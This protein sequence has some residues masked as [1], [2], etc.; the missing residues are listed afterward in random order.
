[1]ALSKQPVIATIPMM[2]T[3]EEIPNEKEANG[4]NPRV[5]RIKATHPMMVSELPT[6]ISSLQLN[7]FEVFTLDL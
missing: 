6:F 2:R 4:I 7:S 5:P 3:P 1:M